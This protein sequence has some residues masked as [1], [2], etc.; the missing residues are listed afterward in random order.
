MERPNG[1]RLSCGAE[2]KSSQTEFYY[3]VFLDVHRV[4]RGT[5]PTASGAC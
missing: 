3:T 4:Y 5:A 2:Q 1:L